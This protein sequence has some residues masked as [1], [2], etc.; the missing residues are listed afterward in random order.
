MTGCLPPGFYFLLMKRLVIMLID[1]WSA[2]EE[3]F[4]EEIHEKLIRS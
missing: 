2:D 3:I 1:E 4:R